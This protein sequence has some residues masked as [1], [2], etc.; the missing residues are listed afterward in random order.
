MKQPDAEEQTDKKP[1]KGKKKKVSN[2]TPEE[3]M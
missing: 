2:L 3:I 1:K